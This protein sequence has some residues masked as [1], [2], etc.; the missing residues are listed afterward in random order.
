MEV[1]P[2]KRGGSWRL[3]GFK[4]GDNTSLSILREVAPVLHPGAKD[5]DAVAQ[6]MLRRD[7]TSGYR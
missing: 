2:R 1:R 4:G 6:E 3:K 7:G 5:P